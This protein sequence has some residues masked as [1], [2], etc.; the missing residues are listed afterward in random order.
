MVDF[1]AN[2]KQNRE[3][4]KSLYDIDVV[5]VNALITPEGGRKAYVQLACGYVALD[6]AKKKKNEII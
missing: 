1:K 2:Q 6:V 4:V 3:T 5:K